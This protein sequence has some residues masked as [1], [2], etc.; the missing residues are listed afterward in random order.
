MYSFFHQNTW[1]QAKSRNKME[2]IEIQNTKNKKNKE[3][4]RSHARYIYKIF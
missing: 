2:H 4:L 3:N 1:Y